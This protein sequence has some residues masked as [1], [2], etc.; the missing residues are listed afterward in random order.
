MFNIERTQMRVSEAGKVL[1]RRTGKGVIMVK[2]HCIKFS[3]N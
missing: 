1:L 3:V 2:M